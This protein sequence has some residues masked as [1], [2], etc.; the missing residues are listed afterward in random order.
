M[1]VMQMTMHHKDNG[2]NTVM[3][4]SLNE[5][6]SYHLH[7]IDEEIGRCKDCLFDDRSWVVRYMLADTNKWLP[8]GARCLSRP[9]G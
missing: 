9:I 8:G 7:G 6:I 5:I 2:K 3:L 4:R 1:G